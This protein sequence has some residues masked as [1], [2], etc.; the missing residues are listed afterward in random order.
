VVFVFRN[1]FVLK[2]TKDNKKELSV[3]VTRRAVV[4][5]ITFQ[6]ILCKRTVLRY[7]ERGNDLLPTSNGVRTI[8]N[9]S[10]V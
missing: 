3:G 6:R 10:Y 8:L 4:N 5:H 1:I 9:T 7:F 2:N